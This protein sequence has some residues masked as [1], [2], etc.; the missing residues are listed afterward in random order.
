MIFIVG[1]AIVGAM[2]A[3]QASADPWPKRGLAANDGVPIWQFG[4]SWLGHNSQVNWQYN[5]DSNTNQ[6]PDFAEFVP[7]LW[8]TQ[9]YHTDQWFNNAWHWLNNGGS[10]HL[11]AF[12]EPDRGDQAH[13]TPGEAVNGW[14]QY[15]E[16][17]AGHAQLGA[18]AVS[19]GGFDWLQQFLNQCQGCHID[20]IPVHWYGGANYEHEFEN[21][22]NRVCSISGSRPVWVTEFQGEGSIDEQSNFLRKAIPF[23][24]N[25]RC[26]YRYSYFGT[27][28]NSK[29]LLDNGGPRLSPLGVQ[30]TFS[31]Y[32]NG[33]GPK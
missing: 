15:M 33:D 6:K 16:P 31:P 9:N 28:D 7:M 2:L 1:S 30:Y 23:L 8:G 21:W 22:I 14:R 19:A 29:V 32:G 11:L 12:N 20:F 13:M 10:G 17:F 24:D 26:V 3:G 4:G 25:N 18:P 5:W 27:A